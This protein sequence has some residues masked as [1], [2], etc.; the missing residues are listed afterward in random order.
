M[1]KSLYH[2]MIH[3]NECDQCADSAVCIATTP[4]NNGPHKSHARLRERRGTGTIFN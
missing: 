2:A 4:R 3:K 1:L